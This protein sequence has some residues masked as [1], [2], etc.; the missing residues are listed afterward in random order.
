M[1]FRVFMLPL[2][3]HF[4]FDFVFHSALAHATGYSIR[5][6]EL[7]ESLSQPG[8]THVLRD[9]VMVQLKQRVS[10][11]KAIGF[12]EQKLNQAIKSKNFSALNRF[13]VIPLKGAGAFRGLLGQIVE[14][15]DRMTRFGLNWGDSFNSKRHEEPPLHGDL[16]SL[17]GNCDSIRQFPQPLS[18]LLPNL[19][20]G[21]L[22]DQTL[23][24]CQFDRSIKMAKIFTS[25]ASHSGSTVYYNSATLT[26]AP[27]L[28]KELLATGHQIEMRN[29]RM[30]AD[31]FPL[32]LGGDK[33]LKWPIWLDT[34][35]PLQDGTS[36]TIPLGH[37]QQTWLISGPLV[38]AR[39]AFF[40]GI[41]GVAFVPQTDIRPAWTGLSSSYVVQSN[42]EGQAKILKAFELAE[43]YLQ[44]IQ[45]EHDHSPFNLTA[46]GYGYL[47]VCNDSTAVIEWFT[48]GTI[49]TYPLIR[50]TELPDLLAN[51][52]PELGSF[53]DSLNEVFRL[54]PHD[55]ELDSS[56][57]DTLRRILA[58]TPYPL[59][60][61]DMV[62]EEL[63][64]Q[65][66]QAKHESEN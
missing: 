6:S 12:L 64:A 34:G 7:F 13:P 1:R 50:S 36:L 57:R 56:R 54:L 15:Q 41:S 2:M 4:M 45:Y 40:L 60:S 61:P 23:S 21:F 11:P 47:G 62:D 38:E 43:S 27:Q 35:V 37:S 63:R 55:A 59:D 22:P 20:W 65:L 26:T 5:P 3:F 46:G 9:Q 24:N 31:F 48:M 10:D 58:M 52:V 16:I 44:R 29:E 28:V 49:S 8:D 14:L 39:I 33:D 51:L 17:L 18:F 66:K 25:L 19:R 42:E 32:I 30:Y 53:N